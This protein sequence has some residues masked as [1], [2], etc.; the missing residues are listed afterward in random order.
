MANYKDIFSSLDDFTTWHSFVMDSSPLDVSVITE[1]L[2]THGDKN[3]AS[4]KQQWSHSW[5]W[6]NFT[7]FQ[8][9]QKLY[10]VTKNWRALYSS[11]VRVHMHR[12][13]TCY[14]RMRTRHAAVSTK[15]RT[16]AKTTH[17]LNRS[18][19]QPPT[20]RLPIRFD[21]QIWAKS[22]G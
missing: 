4:S 22:T 14:A 12:T 11:L 6:I 16:P 7:A 9:G 18:A 21:S 3:S 5:H 10:K 2:S 20:D 1:I 15:T 8:K 19:S 17:L 13:R